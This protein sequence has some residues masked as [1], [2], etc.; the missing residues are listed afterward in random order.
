[1]AV[2]GIGLHENLDKTEYTYFNEKGDT[3]TLNDGSVKLVDKFM[4]LGS[5]I[6]STINVI[7]MHLKKAW[8]VI[9]RLSIIWKSDL[10][11]KIK[12]KAWWDLHNNATSYIKQILEATPHKRA[13]VWPPTPNRMN[14]TCGTLLEKQ[15]RNH[16]IY[17][18]STKPSIKRCT[19]VN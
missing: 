1:M 11:D 6:S 4:Y 9:N 16:V 2:R 14:K 8:I 13:A 5:S 19:C 18:L 12:C 15:G 7:N 3:F 10:S 17:W